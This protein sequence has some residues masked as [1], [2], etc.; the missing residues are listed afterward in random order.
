M[1]E[2]R[3]DAHWWRSRNGEGLVA[4]SPGTF[5]RVT[6]KGAAVLDAVTAGDPV[7]ES[8]L[9]DRLVAAGAV[10]PL[11][12]DPAP[13]DQVTVVIPLFA[14]SQPEI[15]GAQELVDMLAP[16]RTVV[17]D[18]ASPLPVRLE[19]T[20]VIT[21]GTN[22]GP[23]A[24]RNT[25][26]AE[27]TTP[28]VAFVDADIRVTAGDILRLTGHFVD[29]NV[30]FAAPRV[31]TRAGGSVIAEYESV[32][33][34]L[35]MGARPAR[36]RPGSVVPFVPS[37]TLV[38]RSPAMQAGF[39]ES[40]RTGEDVEFV[41]R[42]SGN[43]RQCR[44]EPDVQA[45]HLPRASFAA[46]IRQRFGYG[47][48]AA[49]IDARRPW[50]VAPVR[51]NIFHLLPLGLLLAGQ[52]FWA[53]DALFVSVA[54]TLFN[55]R[56]MGLTVRN[57]LSVAWLSVATASRHLATAITREWWPVFVVLSAISPE[58]EVAFWFSLAGLVLVDIM[59]LRPP[60]IAMFLPLRVL[61]NLAY[62]TGVWAGAF[63][64]RSPRCLLPRISAR[65]RR[66]G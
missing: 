15:D 37:A 30:A 8:A 19:R 31:V 65:P 51:G 45:E 66:G 27:V 13:A 58:V 47:R 25:G 32:G 39:D 7:G 34:R 29:P 44:Y 1:R 62:G 40:M 48:S 41:W 14:R 22:G 55:L 64:R 57:R 60:N 21:R 11:P 59:K 16:L 2:V 49:D 42:E 63:A 9:L 36:V 3:R 24:A 56:G 5:F 20:T 10:H 6:G 54:F 38:A 18:D 33:S 61:D 26:M 12:G 4:G 43:S 46:F 28:F 23:A 53:A 52:M 17:V 35:D 50:S